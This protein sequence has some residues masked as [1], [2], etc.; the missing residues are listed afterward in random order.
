MARNWFVPRPGGHDLIYQEDMGDVRPSDVISQQELFTKFY[1]EAV[2][3]LVLLP[4][5]VFVPSFVS[6]LASLPFC[7]PSDRIRPDIP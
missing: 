1:S 3:Q 5:L 7:G 2:P 6:L 4:Y